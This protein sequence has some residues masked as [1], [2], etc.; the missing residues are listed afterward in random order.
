MIAE[1]LQGAVT[2][3]E[4]VHHTRVVC[5]QPYSAHE[6]PGCLANHAQQTCGLCML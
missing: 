3:S 4:D 6:C 2:G 5:R 1:G